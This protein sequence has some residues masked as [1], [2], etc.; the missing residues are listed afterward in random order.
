LTRSSVDTNQCFSYNTT[1]VPPAWNNVYNMTAV[2]NPRPAAVQLSPTTWW[3]TGGESSGSVDLATT[4][5][6]TVG[7]GFSPVAW[8]LPEGMSQHSLVVVNETSVIMV[9][10]WSA[11]GC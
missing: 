2:R 9:G 11:A 6:F 10:G 3:M 1:A 8:N 5:V 4:E 7:Q